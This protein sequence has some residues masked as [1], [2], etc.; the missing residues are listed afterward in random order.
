MAEEPPPTA[1]FYHATMRL[2]LRP[3]PR[4]DKLMP[5]I[6]VCYAAAS[7]TPTRRSATMAA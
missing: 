7:A 2:C 1:A 5:L 3:F 6:A 4:N